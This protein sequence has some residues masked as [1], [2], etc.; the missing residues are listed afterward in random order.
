MKSVG[1][2]IVCDFPGHPKMQKVANAI[3]EKYG[4]PLGRLLSRKSQ[5]LE[6]KKT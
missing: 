4:G 5:E 2:E 1:S 3:L 6:S